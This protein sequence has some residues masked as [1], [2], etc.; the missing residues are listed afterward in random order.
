MLN[1][2]LEK[3]TKLTMERTY[4]IRR[5]PTV[6]DMVVMLLLFFTVQMLTGMVA[7]LLGFV[8]PATSA[9]DAVDIETYMN[10]QEAL[11]RYVAISYPVSFLLSIGAL[12]LYVRLRGGKRS[13]HINH[14]ASGFN[15]SVVLV[16]ALWLFSAQIILEPLM[17]QLPQSEGGGFGRGFWACFT[18]IVS[19]AVLEELLCRGLIFEVLHK[20]LGVKTSIL[21]SS[22]FF[23]LIHFDIATA[24]VA[25]VAGIIFGVLYV[26]TSSLYTTIIIHSINNTLAFA[27]ICCGVGDMSLYDI[28]GGGVAYWIVYGVAMAI[29][30]ACSIEAYLKVFRR[31]KPKRNS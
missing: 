8:P 27:M 1:F 29:F 19:A 18:A 26:R 3:S 21:F 17:S 30:L 11:G 25:V 5:F 4:K 10:E 31:K 15:P 7:N 23:G 13:I 28:I 9:I 2:A 22:L 20:R 12:W 6:G 24:I 14:S 16:G